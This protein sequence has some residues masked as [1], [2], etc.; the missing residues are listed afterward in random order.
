[1]LI[2]CY[3]VNC[4]SK[5]KKFNYQ[6]LAWSNYYDT[7]DDI[8]IKYENAKFDER[9]ATFAPKSKNAYF[10]NCF[11]IDMHSSVSG[12]AILFENQGKNLAFNTILFD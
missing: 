7:N 4:Q 12:G 5:H 10:Y 11:F 1:M 2:F 3:I 9:N 8:D 6:R